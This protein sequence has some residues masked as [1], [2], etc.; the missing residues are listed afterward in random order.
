M[1]VWIDSD[2]ALGAPRGDV[3]DGFALAAIARA[4]AAG[5]V[6][7]LGVSTVFGNTSAAHAARAARALLDAA[8]CPRVRVVE[9]AAR[10]GDTSAAARAIAALPDGT[11]LLALG[12]LTNVAAALPAMS[13]S[14]ITV[15]VVGGNLR[16]RGRYPPLWPFEFNLAKDA[17]AARA[18]FAGALPRRVYPLDSARALT[19][20]PRWLADLAR[21]SSLGAFLARRSLRWLAYAPLRY[22][23][24][25]FPVWDAVPALDLLDALPGA[26]HDTRPLR[27]IR[28]GLL[29]PE[30]D[31]LRATCLRGFDA[32]AARESLAAL[33]SV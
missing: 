13:R 9:G 12:P 33:V 29:V 15:S 30:G 16:S 4:H 10:P 31:A 8:G 20:G 26:R 11:A 27:C 25:T 5:R 2:I 23:T 7:L 24:L 14:S 18:L 6:E 17:P 21:R 19:V 3:D 32:D 22:R 1:R 28:R